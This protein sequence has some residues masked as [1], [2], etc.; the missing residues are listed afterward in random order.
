MMNRLIT[1]ISALLFV[2]TSAKAT[3][4]VQQITLVAR[5][6]IGQV[7]ELP[8]GNISFRLIEYGNYYRVFVT[9]ENTLPSEALLL[10][11]KKQGERELK[12]NKPKIEFRK[13]YPGSKGTRSVNGLDA[14]TQNF[15]PII[16]QEKYD[17]K[18][19]A[20]PRNVKRLEI[21]IYH[22]EFN[23]NKIIKKGPYGVNYKI[24]EKYI[25]PFDIEV[26]AWSE[27]D[28]DYLATKA[29]VLE[30]LNSV[31]KVAF[32]RNKRH[33]PSLSEQQ[34]P[35][36][37]KKD[38]LVN[39]I[40][41]TLEKHRTEWFIPDKPHIKYTELLTMLEKVDLNAHLYDCRNHESVVHSC[42]YCTLSA[43]EIYHR[44]ND[45]YLALSNRQLTKDAAIKKAAP[46]YNCYQKR[47]RR[48]K[49]AGYTSK[50]SRFYSRITNY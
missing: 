10:F 24:L 29:A 12:K 48:K 9:I 15:V 44:L 39:V 8:Y 30:Y 37:E 26:I 36:R 7:V 2:C 11:K 5:D 27:N 38:S 28:S 17:F 13:T 47:S 16:P 19:D 46:L 31:D 43:S 50:I 40:N 23:P 20:S 34:R 4:E 49:D 45:I 14:L 6:S 3:D 1:F 21:P 22:A 33:R 35:Y 18:I 32:C 42:D 41:T 25:V